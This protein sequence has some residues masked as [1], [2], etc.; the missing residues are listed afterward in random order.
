MKYLL[1]C[2]LSLFLSLFIGNVSQA[3][4]HTV[5]WNAPRVHTNWNAPVQTWNSPIHIHNGRQFHNN[6]IH[7]H[8]DRQFH[9][10]MHNNRHRW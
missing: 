8:N 6:H 4:V 10:G 5:S 7:F 3:R 9:N 2:F 1:I